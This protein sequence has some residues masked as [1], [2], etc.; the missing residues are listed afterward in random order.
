MR[1]IAALRKLLH[2]GDY[3][4]FN[5]VVDTH[6]W[7]ILGHFRTFISPRDRLYQCKTAYKLV[8]QIDEAFIPY[9]NMKAPDAYIYPRS[10][11][12]A[13]YG[14]KTIHF[15]HLN[16]FVMYSRALYKSHN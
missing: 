6:F 8:I 10:M 13:R 11:R 7:A 5:A 14:L 16:S 1:R 4:H 3:R 9:R 12:L 2:G 15:L